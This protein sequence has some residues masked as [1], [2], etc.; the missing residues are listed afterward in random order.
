MALSEF[1]WNKKRNH[2]TY[3]FKE[4]GNLRLN[5]IITTKP[6]RMVHGKP[7]KNIRLA[8]HPN[9]NCSKDAFIIPFV[10]VDHVSSFFGRI[11]NWNFDRNDKRTI[12]RIK[13]S[14]KYKKSQL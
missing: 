5:I 12:K 2:Y 1:R 7:K 4:I 14:W 13:K 9:P 11:Y 10:Y 3:S 8:K 6:I